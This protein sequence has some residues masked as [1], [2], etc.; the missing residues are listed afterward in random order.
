MS[1]QSENFFLFDQTR[2]FV[3]ERVTHPARNLQIRRLERIYHSGKMKP[4]EALYMDKLIPVSNIC[5]CISQQEINK[6][7]RDYNNRLFGCPN[8]KPIRLIGGN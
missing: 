4:F 3:T 5:P 6:A 1:F 2:N 7:I 8:S